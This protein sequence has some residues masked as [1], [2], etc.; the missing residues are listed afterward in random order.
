MKSILTTVA[1]ILI[2]TN[3]IVAQ[4]YVKPTSIQVSS[5]KDSL[6]VNGD[7]GKKHTKKQKVKNGIVMLGI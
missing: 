1:F 7:V 4:T 2:F 5:S 3:N 6:L